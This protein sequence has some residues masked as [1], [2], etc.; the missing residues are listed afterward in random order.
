M[1]AGSILLMRMGLGVLFAYLTVK[2][3]HLGGG[4]LTVAGFTVFF[5]G[6]AYL[7]AHLREKRQ[8]EE[9]LQ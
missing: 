9:R 2:I 5:V 8:R 1:D 6:L 3:F 4:I 7:L